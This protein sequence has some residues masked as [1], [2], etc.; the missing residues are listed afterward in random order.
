MMIIKKTVQEIGC[1]TRSDRKDA[2]AL[3]RHTG[4][5]RPIGVQCFI[6]RPCE[7]NRPGQNCGESRHSQRYDRPQRSASTASRQAEALSLQ[8]FALCLLQPR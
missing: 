3:Q 6:D 8:N 2:S 1:G 4:W 7:A 5:D